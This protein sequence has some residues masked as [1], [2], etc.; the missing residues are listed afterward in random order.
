MPDQTVKDAADQLNNNPPVGQGQV[1][2][3]GTQPASTTPP[4]DISSG[5]PAPPQP[6]GD[7]TGTGGNQPSDAA[8]PVS[9]PPV[10]AGAEPALNTLGTQ[11]DQVSAEPQNMPEPKSAIAGDKPAEDQDAKEDEK[12]DDGQSPAQ[13]PSIPPV[14]DSVVPPSGGAP[15]PTQPG[16]PQDSQTGVPEPDTT[17]IPGAAPLEQGAIGGVPTQ[18]QQTQPMQPPTPAQDQASPAPTSGM[19]DQ[20]TTGTDDTG[21]ADD[22]KK[23][24]SP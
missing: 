3:A 12:K 23:N 5:A 21:D 15:E 9:P 13:A 1:P 16:M 20:P 24:M 11:G 22:L 8:R 14:S 7:L 18:P 4:A 17:S 2:P 6:G 10:D 19:T